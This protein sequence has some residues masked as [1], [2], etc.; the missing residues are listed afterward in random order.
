MEASPGSPN[1]R[2]LVL[3]VARCVTLGEGPSSQSTDLYFFFF[4]AGCLSH[5]DPFASAAATV[6]ATRL[7][8]WLFRAVSLPIKSEE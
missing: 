6:C 3:P 4:E 5:K 7:Y 2:T 8:I 1:A